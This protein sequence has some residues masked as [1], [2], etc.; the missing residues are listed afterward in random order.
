MHVTALTTRYPTSRHE[1]YGPVQREVIVPDLVIPGPPSPAAGRGIDAAML[2][3]PLAA[4]AGRRDL[5]P[6]FLFEPRLPPPSQLAR[7]RFKEAVV[8]MPR[9]HDLG[10]A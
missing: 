10:A 2:A 9:S 4:T 5:P 3:A 1:A 7:R 6:P 8:T